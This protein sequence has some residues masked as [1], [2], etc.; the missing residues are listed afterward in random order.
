LDAVVRARAQLVPAALFCFLLSGPGR[1]ADGAAPA[2]GPPA[3]GIEVEAG[4]FHH[5]LTAGLP[6]WDG[7]RL[8]LRLGPIGGGAPSGRRAT[9]QLELAREERGPESAG[10]ASAAAW[11]D[12]SPNLF[13]FAALTASGGDDFYPQRRG[14]LELHWKLPRHERLVLFAGGGRAEFESADVDFWTAGVTGYS[15]RAVLSYRYWSFDNRAL[16]PDA[17]SGRGSSH[18]I[19]ALLGREEKGALDVRLLWGEDLLRNF[20][21]GAADALLTSRT[22]SAAW[23]R[24]LS[25]R[26][27]THLQA[28][29]GDK[30][31]TYSRRGIE[32][33]LLWRGGGGPR[34]G[35]SKSQ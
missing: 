29:W 4:V 3:A 16:S 1:G 33:R 25:Q 23:R 22:A 31:D 30:E 24:R 17:F 28:E 26:W 21:F 8:L 6:D 15:R 9:V 13:T 2:P 18:M 7:E 10:L 19:G 32:L 27:G 5:A 34:A 20:S 12:W 14:D 11:V 35:H